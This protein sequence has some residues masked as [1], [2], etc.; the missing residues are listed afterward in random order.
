MV[1]APAAL[2]TVD[3]ACEWLGQHRGALLGALAQ[4]GALLL[5]GFPLRSAEDFDAFSGL[6]FTP[7][8]YQESPRTRCGLTRPHACLRR[9]KHRQRLAF[10]CTTRWHRRRFRRKSSFSLPERC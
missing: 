1:E 4:E 7:F 6:E 9:M 8:T 2:A 3:D 5:R 10:S